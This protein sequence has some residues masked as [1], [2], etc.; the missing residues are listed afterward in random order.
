MNQNR[1]KEMGEVMGEVTA[2]EP[3]SSLPE[4]GEVFKVYVKINLASQLRRGVLSI[5]VAG[6]T[7]WV[8]Y[9]YEKQPHKICP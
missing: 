6:S 2:I 3:E 8:C 5:T 7:R 9:F 4:P 1:V